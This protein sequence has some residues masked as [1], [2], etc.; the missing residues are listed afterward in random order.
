VIVIIGT[1]SK[2]SFA[3]DF[4]TYLTSQMPSLMDQGVAGYNVIAKDIQ[5]PIQKPGI[6]NRVAGLLGSFILQDIESDEAVTKAFNP[7]NKTIQ[8]RWPDKVQFYTIVEQFDSFLGWFDKNYDMN[9]AGGSTYLVSRLLDAK[10]LTGNDEALKGALE[11]VLSSG[12][13][14]S[15]LNHMVAGKGV[16]EAKPR[17]GSN[18]VNPAWRTTYVHVGK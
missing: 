6:P 16:Q 3:L 7:I 18:A 17:G 13:L 12:N 11:V 14:S 9:S 2:E 15:M 10:A 1:D 8:Q 5:N 4:V